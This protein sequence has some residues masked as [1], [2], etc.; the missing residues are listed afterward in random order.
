M[1]SADSP[2]WYVSPWLSG[3]WVDGQ[4]YLIDVKASRHYLVSGAVGFL[5]MSATE[6]RNLETIQR[7]AEAL[8]I[9]SATARHIQDL[10]AAGIL[11]TTKPDAKMRP[12][13][14]VIDSHRISKESISQTI[15]EAGEIA[16]RLVASLGLTATITP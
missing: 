16:M 13:I 11:Q 14:E 4:L 5:I 7:E 2:S 15:L 8:G 12:E 1:P 6:G 3:Q 10:L 9:P